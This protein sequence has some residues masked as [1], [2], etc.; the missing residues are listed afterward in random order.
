MLSFAH[1]R[2]YPKTYVFLVVSQPRRFFAQNDE[3]IEGFGML[4]GNLLGMCLEFAQISEFARNP[5]GKRS[6]PAMRG[7]LQDKMR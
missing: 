1:G 6:G 4:A 7:T 2:F 5:I 3:G